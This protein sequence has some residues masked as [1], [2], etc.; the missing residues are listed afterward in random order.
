MTQAS[1]ATSFLATVGINTSIT[2]IGSAYQ[3]YAQMMN[4]LAFLD[5]KQVR[6]TYDNPY[7]TAEFALMGKQ[8]GLK[9]DFFIA[10]GS[11]SPEWQIAQIKANPSIVASVEGY[12]ES[13][14]W[15]QT[16]HGAT[17]VAATQAV[18]QYI[19]GAVKSDAA[20]AGVNVIQATF[21]DPSSFAQYGD[22]SAYADDAS[23]HTYFGTGNNPSGSETTFIDESQTVSPGRPT[24]ATEAG[25]HT[26]AGSVQ[27]VSQLVQAK[28]LLD[29]L[30]EQAKLGVKLTY[31][32]ELADNYA[33]PGNTNSE[34]HFGLFNN[35]WTPKLAAL[36]LHNTTEIL[37]DP[38]TGGVAPAA[39]D[40]T[41]D[42]LPSSVQTSLY[43]KSDGTFVLVVWNDVRLSGPSV[44]SDIVVAPIATSLHLGQNFAR[45]AVF[46][47]LTGTSSV[48]AY[49]NTNAIALQVLD[50]PL[51]IELSHDPAFNIAD[52]PIAAPD[53]LL[54]N[55][56]ASVGIH[57]LSIAG[58]NGLVTVRLQ[59]STGTLS[60]LDTSGHLLVSNT[61]D[62]TIGGSLAAINAELAT[63]TYTGGSNVGD[64]LV[65]ITK[66][67]AAGTL[68]SRTIPVLIQAGTDAS[69]S[70][71]PALSVPGT[72]SAVAGLPLTLPRAVVSDAYAA[73]HAGTMTLTISDMSGLL[74]LPATG[75]EVTG[76]A[77]SS[78]VATG[79]FSQIVAALGGL[80][81]TA[82]AGSTSD[83]VTFQVTDQAGFS[84]NATTAVT[85]GAW[86][87]P[88]APVLNSVSTIAP[89]TSPLITT[90]SDTVP[91]T[92]TASIPP[93]AVS[94]PVPPFTAPIASAAVSSAP[95]G[96]GAAVY[97]FFDSS[98]GTQFL[99]AS[100]TERDAVLASRPD[101]VPEGVGI[102]AVAQHAGDADAIGVFRFFDMESGTHFYTSSTA[103]RDSVEATRSDL[104]Y[105][106]VSF[107]EHS[108]AAAGD[109][110][111]YR[112]FNANNGT[113]FYTASATERG[114]ILATRPDLISE[115]VSFYAPAG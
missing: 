112:F 51:I 37:A 1:S 57:G 39:L 19:Y 24:I 29:L 70:G 47:P 13:D 108:S 8:L 94:D 44:Q 36:A 81:Y 68:A 42:G 15:W 46:D 80:T 48:A 52:T 45:I 64:D 65:T 74:Y 99:T 77:S 85:V 75:A 76:N 63:A 16:F 106:G 78:V 96:D 25:Y 107:Y 34:D 27:G 50:H 111:V 86:T 104:Q 56:L 9:F 87:D 12:N 101:L 91:S 54:A 82:V 2:M 100:I 72:F 4:A 59:S 58:G 67:D 20:L 60:L 55:P 114:T 32:W 73:T 49:S 28:Y 89:V 14:R 98:S 33:D 26:T 41:F 43:Q 7:T 90:P 103:E 23:T 5:V 84:S 10:L 102:G 115:G 71:G 113:H 30:F 17:G 79:S 31:L 40:Y 95:S 35:D 61:N 105:E 69:N 83:S 53:T 93:V 92:L 88:L 22:M 66:G 109:T 6:D 62:V 38:G 110:A 11:A 3:N 21:A 97:R 18:Q